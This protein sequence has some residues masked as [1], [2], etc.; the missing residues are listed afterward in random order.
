MTI[1]IGCSVFDSFVQKNL[2]GMRGISPTARLINDLRDSI[3]FIETYDSIGRCCETGSGFVISEDGLIL[4]ANHV[5]EK[6]SGLLFKNIKVKLVKDGVISTTFFT[7]KVIKRNSSRDIALIKIINAI[8][9]TPMVVANADHRISGIDVF[10]LGF[11]LGWEGDVSVSKGIVSRNIKDGKV[12]LVEHDAKILP[13]SSGGPL[14]NSNGEVLGIN[15]GVIPDYQTVSGLNYAV[16][17]ETIISLMKDVT[18]QKGKKFALA[19]TPTPRPTATPRATPTRTAI[20][21]PTFTPTPMPRHTPTPTAIP[22]KK[23]QDSG[24][25]SGTLTFDKGNIHYVPTRKADVDVDDFIAELTFTTPPVLTKIVVDFG[26]VF[27]YKNERDFDVLSLFIGDIVGYRVF[28]VH[29]HSK[30]NC[31]NILCDQSQATTISVRNISDSFV[32]GFITGVRKNNTITLC[33]SGD[34]GKVTLN[35]KPVAKID[36]SPSGRGDVMALSGWDSSAFRKK[37]D[38]DTYEYSKLIDSVS[39]QNFRVRSLDLVYEATI[40]SRCPS[41]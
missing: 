41:N 12:N 13:G 28:S 26:F 38:R 23:N 19:P 36:V 20:P 30:D 24:V 6:D 32:S 40:K 25:I 7:A 33:V 37:L 4:T 9:L 31:L 27:H 17:S 34:E 8:D 29:M 3:V 5:V 11:P 35:G 21:Y 14:V 2:D 15:V 16:P 1:A 39:F 10:A 22:I 18:V